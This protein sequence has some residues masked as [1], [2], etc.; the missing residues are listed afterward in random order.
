MS[1]DGSARSDPL[2]VDRRNSA[3]LAILWEQDGWYDEDAGKSNDA[4]PAAT[5]AAATATAANGR[6]R[7]LQATAVNRGSSRRPR[8]T[9][10]AG[11]RSRRRHRSVW[12]RSRRTR[13][14]QQGLPRGGD[15]GKTGELAR[16]RTASKPG[17]KLPGFWVAGQAPVQDVPRR[18]DQKGEGGIITSFGPACESAA[19]FG[20]GLG[21]SGMNS[22]V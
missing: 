13:R 4:E 7:R 16:W 15:R 10:A 18:D 1:Q 6:S 19:M 3:V 17:G 11:D 5:S 12:R 14:R 21:V 2:V 9:A 22:S 20:F 8:A